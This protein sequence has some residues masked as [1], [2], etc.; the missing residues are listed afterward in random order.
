MRVALLFEEL[1][2]VFGTKRF[3]T[4]FKTTPHWIVLGFHTVPLINVSTSYH[5]V[6]SGEMYKIQML[7]LF[8]V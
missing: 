7:K 2:A 3:M 5:H 4:I 8:N 6:L 1:V